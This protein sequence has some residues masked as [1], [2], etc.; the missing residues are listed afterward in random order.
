MFV[1]GSRQRQSIYDSTVSALIIIKRMEDGGQY[2]QKYSQTK[3]KQKQ[4]KQTNK[5]TKAK[6]Q[7]QQQTKQTNFEHTTKASCVS[8]N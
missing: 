1:F 2:K 6:Q 3:K 8:L 4:N 5:Q 7:Q